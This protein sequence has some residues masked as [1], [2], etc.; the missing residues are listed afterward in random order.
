MAVIWLNQSLRILDIVITQG[1]SF[2]D[3]LRYSF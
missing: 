3:F 2:V 1:A